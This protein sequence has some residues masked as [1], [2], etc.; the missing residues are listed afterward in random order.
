MVARLQEEL[1][2]ATGHR[3]RGEHSAENPGF[4]T[5]NTMQSLGHVASPSQTFPDSAGHLP[6]VSALSGEKS[7]ELA[8]GIGPPNHF[9]NNLATIAQAEEMGGM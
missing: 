1:V 9:F 6:N 4:P 2:L 5:S 7:S 3:N 8:G